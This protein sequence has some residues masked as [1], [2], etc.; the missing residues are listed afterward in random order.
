MGTEADFHL[1]SL[2]IIYVLMFRKFCTIAKDDDNILETYKPTHVVTAITFGAD[3]HVVFQEVSVFFSSNR[4]SVNA[5]LCL[6][7]Q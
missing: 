6:F 3:A 1:S 4:T 7:V 5:N 2:K